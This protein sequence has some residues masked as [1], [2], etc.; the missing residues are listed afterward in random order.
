MVEA[1]KSSR[2]IVSCSLSFSPSALTTVIDDLRPNGGLVS[3]I[4]KRSPGSA[5]SA[6]STW[7]GLSASSEPM[8][9]RSRFMTQSRA[10][11]STISQPCERVEAQV[12]LLVG[13]EVG[14]VARDH[15][16]AASR[17]PPVP[18]AGSQIVMPGCGPHDLDDRPD[19]RPRREVLA[20]AGLDV[21]GVLLEQPLVGVALDVGVERQPRLA[22][23]QVD[24]QAAQLG[25]ILDPV[26][27]L[28]EDDAEHARLPAELGQEV[29]VVDLELVA[30]AG[31]QARPVEAL[32]DERRGAERRLRLLVGHLEEEQVGELL[33]VVAVGEAVVAQDVAVVPEALDEAVLGAHLSVTV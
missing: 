25:G 12:A 23:D 13:I 30:V 3:T 22:V 18:Q 31:E 33:E 2:T 26:L 21:L 4:S 7:I 15:S 10:V 9:C 20:G 32:G 19:Q 24:D 8:P 27:R 6:S 11:L 29:A 5:L 28:A 14:V 1:Q 16:W 17:N